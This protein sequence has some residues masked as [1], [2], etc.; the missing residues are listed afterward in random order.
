LLL[1]FMVGHRGI[2]ANIAKINAIHKMANPSN[3]KDVM[4]L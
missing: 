1:G 2:E 4:K 3:K